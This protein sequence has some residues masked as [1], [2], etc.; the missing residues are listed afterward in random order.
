MMQP[1]PAQ[2]PHPAIVLILAASWASPSQAR[3]RCSRSW[4]ALSIRHGW[5]QRTKV[6]HADRTST[7]VVE[8]GISPVKE[9]DTLVYLE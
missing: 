2:G 1:N 5:T 7:S 9:S 4:L 3:Q 8:Q 6:A